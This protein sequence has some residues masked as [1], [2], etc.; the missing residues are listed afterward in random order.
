MRAMKQVLFA[1]AFAGILGSLAS[2]LVFM[3]KRDKPGEKPDA[4]RASR[5]MRALALR[6]GSCVL[7]AWKLGYIRPTGSAVGA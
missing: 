7:V 1:L 4:E 2:A 3:L 6:V 5:M